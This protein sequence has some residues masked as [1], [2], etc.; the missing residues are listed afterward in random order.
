MLKEVERYA[1]TINNIVRF[2]FF[3][4]E[5]LLFLSWNVHVLKQLMTNNRVLK[6]KGVYMLVTVPYPLFLHT[7]DYV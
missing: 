2:F 7:Q 5:V 6:N 4:F 3:F 1:E